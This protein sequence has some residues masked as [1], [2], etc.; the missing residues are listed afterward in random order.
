[1]ELFY[2]VNDTVYHFKNIISE[3]GRLWGVCESEPY[4]GCGAWL[5]SNGFQFEYHKRVEARQIDPP[6]RS[7]VPYGY[8]LWGGQLRDT[9]PHGR[10]WYMNGGHW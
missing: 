6:T 10:R 5:D 7:A 9:L 1:M 8:T 4:R 3:N 2:Q